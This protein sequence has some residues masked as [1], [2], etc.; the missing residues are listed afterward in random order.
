MT[1]KSDI[2]L[3]LESQTWKSQTSKKKPLFQ[4]MPMKLP[5]IITPTNKSQVIPHDNA[6]EHIHI[7]MADRRKSI[8]AI[9]LASFSAKLHNM[10]HD[11]EANCVKIPKFPKYPF[12]DH[13]SMLGTVP[14]F[15]LLPKETPINS[16]NIKNIKIESGRIK[17]II[18]SGMLSSILKIKKKILKNNEHD[19][20]NVNSLN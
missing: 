17:R 16:D 15:E 8:L 18:T 10:V 5:I 4:S 6:I 7:P 20:Y 3:L 14:K 11:D 12:G 19:Y 2:E 9:P 13:I 1:T